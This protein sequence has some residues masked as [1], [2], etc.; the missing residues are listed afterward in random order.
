MVYEAAS[1]VLPTSRAQFLTA[2]SRRSVAWVSLF[3]W[4]VAL[5]LLLASS[6]AWAAA[7]STVPSQTPA[8]SAGGPPV[9]SGPIGASTWPSFDNGNVTLV[10]T[11][12]SPSLTL[13]QDTSPSVRSTLTFEHIMEVSTSGSR[14]PVSTL[15]PVGLFARAYALPS[16]STGFSVVVSGSIASPQGVWVNMTGKVTVSALSQV[17][18]TGLPV[19]QDPT[20]EIPVTAIG[21][22]LGVVDVG[23]SFHLSG[24]AT[25]DHL[26]Q[27]KVGVTLSGWP[28]VDPADTLALEW[29]FFS[30][31]NATA[32]VA[33]ASSAPPPNGTV[34]ISPCATEMGLGIGQPIWSNSTTALEAVQMGGLVSYVD[35]SNSGVI[36]TGSGSSQPASLGAALFPISGTNLVRLL[37][38]APF[39][40]GSFAAL[41]EDPTIGLV[42]TLPSVHLPPVAIPPVF[43]GDLGAFLVTLAASAVVILAVGSIAR[44]REKRRLRE[45]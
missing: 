18:L 13:F 1:M 26:G 31:G 10:F 3:P 12:A 15:S 45:I 16:G 27:A 7:P 38:L 23:V 35:W 43:Q 41:E 17:G 39:G 36:T 37:Q 30:P 2:P 6:P 11:G 42:P 40:L 21:A 19:W 9:P 28:W 32:T 20:G 5:V 34:G 24:N 29:Q 22:S 14:G 25:P 44:R 4:V 33:C 8:P